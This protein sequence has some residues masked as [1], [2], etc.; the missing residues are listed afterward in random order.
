MTVHGVS[1]WFTNVFSSHLRGGAADRSDRLNVTEEVEIGRDRAQQVGPAGVEDD[2]NVP[3][4]V[5]DVRRP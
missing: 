3:L 4:S 1:G 2:E 5:E